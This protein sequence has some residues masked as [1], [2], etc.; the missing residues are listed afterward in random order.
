M[1]SDSARETRAI[2]TGLGLTCFALFAGVSLYTHSPYDVMD[3][4]ATPVQE[5]QNK[6]GLLG[7]QLAHHAFCLYGVG[8][9]V[10]VFALLTFGCLM[11][12][13]RTMSGFLMRCLGGFLLTL[14]VCAWAGAMDGRGTSSEVFPAGPGGLLGGTLLAPPLVSYFGKLGV[15]LV[16]AAA[17]V[18]CCLLMAPTVTEVAL[19]LIGRAVVRGCEMGLDRLLGRVPQTTGLNVPKPALAGAVAQAPVPVGTDSDCLPAEMGRV[20]VLPAMDTRVR[21]PAPFLSEQEDDDED[22]EEASTP[23]TRRAK[24]N[25]ALDRDQQSPEELA[26]SR[27]LEL[28]GGRK[29]AKTKEPEEEELTEEEQAEQRR[30]EAMRQAEAA[31]AERLEREREQREEGER[32][33]KEAQARER[34][35][36]LEQERAEKEQKLAKQKEKFAAAMAEAAAEG[37]AE[38]TGEKETAEDAPEAPPE[39]PKPQ[40][41]VHYDLP[42]V[43]LLFDKDESP[44]V[45]SELLTARGAKLVETLWDFNIGARLVN[46]QT[47]PTVT[48]FELELE[49]GIHVRKVVSL[50]DNLAMAMKAEHGVRIIA[51]IPGK[52]SIGIEIPNAER[53]K[54]CIRPILE[55]PQFRAK[56]GSLPLILGRDAVGNPLFPDLATM[57][58]LLIAGTT[59]SG[60]SVCLNSIILSLLILKKP[61]EVKLILVDPKQVEMTDFKGIPHLLCPVVTDMKLAAGV[62]TWAVQKMEERY[63]RMGRIAVRNITSFNKMTGEER[64]ARLP[65]GADPEL[66]KEN[67]P[68]I[69]IVVDEFAD[70]M[71]TS[72][73]EI[74]QA[75]CRLAQKARAAGIHVILATQRPSA[76]VITG[77]IKSNLPCR[78]CFQVKSKIDSRIVLDCGGG[79]KLAGYGDM[80]Y[81]GPG[82]S[83]QLR[84]KGVFTDDKEIRAIVGFCKNQAEPVYS[85]EIEKVATAAA[86]EAGGG[87]DAPEENNRQAIELDD[88]FDEAVE[89]FLATG[90]ASTS[91]LQRRMCLGYTRAAKL[92]DQMEARGIVGPDRGPKGRELLITQ[93]SWEQYKRASNGGLTASGGA[94]AAP[95]AK[96]ALA[97]GGADDD[98]GAVP[99]AKI[100]NPNIHI[101]EELIK[102]LPD[103]DEP[104]GPYPEA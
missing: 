23:A 82:N 45:S 44:P 61:H 78:I 74:E 101:D 33:T 58:H 27:R 31:N 55:S 59:G 97:S 4:H 35:Q 80:L 70:L 73:K 100:D 54:V 72:G 34:L 66:Y 99:V 81:V 11:C 64:I 77:L 63:E 57:P 98:D 7:A 28:D 50:Q 89:V 67:M 8:A 43:D 48:M 42:T 37:A 95:V 10:L 6:A 96:V 56:A 19:G 17:S 21:A 84:A 30:D 16:L 93:E 76:E 41:P 47:G 79:E 68:Y 85:D 22:E 88:K 71:M 52:S 1:T 36:K 29:P 103:E 14:L 9:W 40:L 75:I 91:L 5:I 60:K 3:F 26:A 51:P 87:E 94:A 104:R 38:E 12:S 39:K 65:E 2:V 62:L 24:L 69:V 13:L 86:R 92:C 53:H 20:D 25:A 32:L 46:V 83:N 15:F 90:R 49:A 18:L 102:Q